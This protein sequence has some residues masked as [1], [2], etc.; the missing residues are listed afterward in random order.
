MNGFDATISARY[1]GTLGSFALDV[2]FEVPMR[3]ITALFGPSGC[4]KTTILRC[5][6]GLIRMPGRLMVGGELWQDDAAGTFRRPYERQIGYVFQEASLFAHLSVRRN[7]LYGHRRAL[8]RGAAEEIR[9][10]DV[11]DL[12]GIGH[13]LDR[14]TG[15]LSGGERQRVAVGRALL[16]QPRLLLMDEPLSALDRMTK[17]EILPYFEAIHTALSIPVLYVSHDI[18]EIERLADHMVLLDSGR[19]LAAGALSE[20]LADSRFPLARGRAASTVL[21]ARV[22]G[23]S[24]EDGLTAMDVDGET[25]LLPGQ[26]GPPGSKHRVRIAATDVSLAMQRPSLTTILNIV[27]VRVKEIEPLDDA[28]INVVVNVGHREGGRKLLVRVTR[29]A[30]RTLG[31][32]PGQDL[33][34]QIKA[35]SLVASSE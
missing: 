12:L 35:V 20:L 34:A 7:L 14:A 32:G 16:A 21:E 18:S 17:E 1:A 24:P 33:Y 9:L 2:A 28:Q 30:Q 23:F 3:G 4:G 31:F 15:A 29:R 19:V 22:A 13:L 11:V 5:V 10:D 27:P 6:A 8:K 25:L 26:V